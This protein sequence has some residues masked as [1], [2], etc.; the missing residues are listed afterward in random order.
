MLFPRRPNF[1]ECPNCELPQPIEQVQTNTTI[2]TPVT[3]FGEDGDGAYNDVEF[4]GSDV[5]VSG[6][7]V[8]RYQCSNCGFEITEDVPKPTGRTITEREELIETP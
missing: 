1:F 5:H 7:W 4:H 2:T 3:I 8:D 6:G